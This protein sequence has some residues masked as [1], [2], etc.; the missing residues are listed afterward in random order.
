MSQSLDAGTPPSAPASLLDAV[1]A[2]D[3]ALERRLLYPGAHPY[4]GASRSTYTQA[5]AQAL[6]ELG[7]VRLWIGAGKMGWGADDA[8][9]LPGARVETLGRLLHSLHVTSITVD[10]DAGSEDILALLD[11]VHALRAEPS[12]F[13]ALQRWTKE[14]GARSVHVAALDMDGVRYSDRRTD[15]P[16]DETRQGLQRYLADA[17]QDPARVAEQL[18]ET[19][20]D[21]ETLGLAAAR[22]EL[23]QRL[24]HVAPGAERELSERIIRLL[25]ALPESIRADLLR[26]RTPS[27]SSML[28]R[29]VRPLP[30]RDALTAL[31]E[32]GQVNGSVPKGTTA[33]LTQI[34]HCL[35]DGPTLADGIVAP[36]EENVDAARVASALEA[37]FANRAERDFNPEDYQRRLDELARQENLTVDRSTHRTQALEDAAGLAAQTGGIAALTFADALPDEE[38]PL[39][40]RLDRSLP[41]LLDRKRSDLLA[42]ASRAIRARGAEKSNAGGTFATRLAA[43]L[44]ALLSLDGEP[45]GRDD[46]RAI[47]ALVPGDVVAKEALQQLLAARPGQDVELLRALLLD[48]D[49]RMLAGLLTESI[50]K[51]PER[52]ARIRSLL[53][54]ARSAEVRKLLERLQ[55][56]AD[57]RVRTTALAV[58]VERDGAAQHLDTLT[59]AVASPDLEFARWALQCL[60]SSSEKAED[61]T[62]FLGWMLEAQAGRLSTDVSW[63]IASLLLQRGTPGIRRAAAAALV[64]CGS[65]SLRNARLARR[66]VGGLETHREDPEVARVIRRFQW[67][68][69]RW[70]SLLPEWES[71][72]R[73]G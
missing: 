16:S 33:I 72:A 29:L 15:S 41:A 65:V 50:E 55:H 60:A 21:Q 67:S 23:L 30:L 4:V 25:A 34:L 53:R 68:L 54:D 59:D 32:L 48:C 70:L 24:E 40:E 22:A 5:W 62:D 56:H 46:V 49:G 27:G 31:L 64:L 7:A 13:Q 20:K 14:G 35:P 38:R 69:V 71:G 44:P 66:L 47:L 63:R 42:L 19:W 10:V 12:P 73:R 18:M 28:A 11:L 52:I 1:I 9:E 45:G 6:A 36:G 26:I 8:L 17:E 58:L 51:A 43:S 37:M 61:V 39:L 2:L 3:V 57:R